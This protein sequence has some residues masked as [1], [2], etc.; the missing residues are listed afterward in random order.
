MNRLWLI[1]GFLVLMMLPV[2]HAEEVKI[3][4]KADKVEYLKQENAL[5]LIGNVEVQVKDITIKSEQLDYDTR[6]KILYSDTDFTFTQIDKNKKKTTITGKSFVYNVGIKRIEA[7]DVYLTIPAKAPG[8]EVYIKGDN[9]T[10]YNNGKRLVFINGFYTTCDHFDEKLHAG[11]NAVDPYDVEN[12]KNRIVHYAMEADILDFIKDERVLAWN[13]TIIAFD[14][15]TFWFPYW[16]IPLEGAAGIKKP[17]IDAGQNP[18]E[19]SF[20]KFKGPYKWN[21]YHDGSWFLTFMEKKGIGL[22]FDHD[23][24]AVPNSITQ[25]YFYGL[26]V[27]TGLTDVPGALFYPPSQSTLTTQQLDTSLNSFLSPLNT[28]GANKF[29]DYHFRIQH[30]QRLLEHT[31]LDTTFENKDFYNFSAFTAARNK[32]NKFTWSIT[33]SQNFAVDSRTNLQVDTTLNL[34]QATNETET[35]LQVAASPSPAVPG[36]PIKSSLTRQVTSPENRTANVK[37]RLGSQTNLNLDSNWRAQKGFSFKDNFEDGVFI[38]SESNNTTYNENWTS[39]LN[40]TSQINEKLNLTSRLSY[41][42]VLNTNNEVNKTLQPS[43]QL[44]Q[45][46]DWA[47]LNLKYEDFF[48]FSEANQTRGQ[49]KK[50]PELDLSGIKLF[51]ETFPLSFQTVIG[52][53]FEQ[54]TTTNTID[55]PNL[56]TEI[57]RNKLRL[58][59]DNKSHDLG[60]GMNLDFGGTSFEQRFYQTQD[61]EYSFTAQANLRNTLTPYFTPEIRYYRTVLDEVNNNSP[62]QNFEALALNKQNNVTGSLSFV[63]LPEF[64]L[65]VNSG[66]DYIG[67]RYNPIQGSISSQIGN[68]FVLNF[69]TIYTPIQI[70]DTDVGKLLRDTSGNIYEHGEEKTTFLVRRQDVGSF[71]PFGGRWG[72]STLGFRYRSTDQP[73]NIGNLSTFG[74]DEGIPQGWEFGS[75]IN[76]DFHQGRINNFNNEIKFTF[77]ENWLWH[78]ELE[79]LFS[80]QPIDLSTAIEDVG[81]L[82]IPFKLVFRKD[83]HDFVFTASWDSFYQQL[84][85]DLSLLAF[86][87]STSQLVGQANQNI[88]NTTSQINR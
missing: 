78:T 33:D 64:T 75:A 40:F 49:I 72:S 52:R 19:G 36:D 47:T 15:K 29:E 25:L 34:D 74:K 20:I 57:A 73:L 16:Y 10:G 18:V 44:A 22:G 13:A 66:Y 7:I 58:S 56:L 46:L 86:P 84:N 83:F 62:F 27:S 51:K 26:P 60:M 59:I 37:F 39:N 45:R 41:N 3:K 31:Q 79:L 5:R 35:P 38:N 50:L 67:R 61:A 71:S 68:N 55:N 53:Y 11:E 23:W 77:G 1:L 28:Y 63:N 30:R 87:Y 65:K 85:F 88:Q 9:M 24:I 21:D 2:A 70:Q 12:V 69:Q 8:Q 82:E 4:Y 80:V 42:S 32:L 43:I 54:T 17:D 6:Q 76:Y 48:S 14:A 81:A